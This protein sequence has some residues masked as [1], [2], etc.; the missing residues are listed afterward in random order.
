MRFWRVTDLITT[1][2]EPDQERHLL[3]MRQQAGKLDLLVLDEFGYPIGTVAVAEA[4]R[5]RRTPIAAFH[6]RDKDSSG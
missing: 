4:L 5:L 1:L 2:C 3:Q 6:F